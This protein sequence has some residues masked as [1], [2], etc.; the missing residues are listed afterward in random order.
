[1]NKAG[2]EDGAW[3]VAVD[4]GDYIDQVGD[5]VSGSYVVVERTRFQGS[6]R[7]L[8]VKE[9]RYYRDRYELHPNS[10]DASY[11]PIVVQHDEAP[12]DETQV[13]IVG[14]VL[15]AYRDLMSR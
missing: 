7:E 12:D 4:A 1:M 9:I 14:L 6:E 10:T 2:I 13:R 11:R 5:I 8:T 15:G 3:I